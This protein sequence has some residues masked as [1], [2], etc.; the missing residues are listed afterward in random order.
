M[1]TSITVAPCGGGAENTTLMPL[2]V[3][4]ILSCTGMRIKKPVG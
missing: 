3:E 4:H 1:D 2:P